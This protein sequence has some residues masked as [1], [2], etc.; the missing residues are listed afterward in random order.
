MRGELLGWDRP[1]GTGPACSG[2]TQFTTLVSVENIADV[3]HRLG[4]A[5]VGVEVTERGMSAARAD[6]LE[7]VI[8]AGADDEAQVEGGCTVAGIA[9]E[10]GQHENTVREHLEALV[11]AGMVSRRRRPAS[12][13][14][15]PA[16]VYVA[17]SGGTLAGKAREY[18]G[19]AAALAG[20]IART[21]ADPKA[22]AISAGQAWGETLAGEP[23]VGGSEALADTAAIRGT[24]AVASTAARRRVVALLDELGFAPTAD[25]EATTVRLARCP[26]LE[27]A[28]QYPEV[29]CWVHLGLAKGMLGTLGGDPGRT[30]VHPFV[31]PGACRLDLLTRNAA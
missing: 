21:S 28:K 23:G 4:P 2:S 11:Q 18:A 29:V 26:L 7:R 8:A 16:A 27:V 24:A 19:L 1:L 25:A 20:Q 5:P 31:E 3:T 14:G 13:R 30:A 6:I 15:R 10:T 17:R 22:D 9:A 12:G